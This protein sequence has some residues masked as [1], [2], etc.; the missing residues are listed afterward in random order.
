M[1][2]FVDLLIFDEKTFEYE[3]VSLSRRK[4]DRCVPPGRVING[5]RDKET[6][7]ITYLAT[8]YDR[9]QWALRKANRKP[10]AIDFGYVHDVKF[11]A[12]LVLTFRTRWEEWSKLFG[13]VVCENIEN[14][15]LPYIKARKISKKALMSILSVMVPGAVVED[16]EVPAAVDSEVP[17]DDNTEVVNE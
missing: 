1:S 16:D 17:E 8:R 10:P 6:G 12:L 13:E 11:S 3:H 14:S 2:W 4:F 7:R 5:I 9:G 15:T